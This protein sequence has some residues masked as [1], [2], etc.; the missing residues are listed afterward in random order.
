[1]DMKTKFIQVPIPIGVWHL[2]EV[3]GQEVKEIAGE[4]YKRQR[5]PGYD[6]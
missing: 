6:R 5:L 1:M 3:L 2:K 4:R